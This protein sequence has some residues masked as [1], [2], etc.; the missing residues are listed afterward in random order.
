MRKSHPA[1]QPVT[2]QKSTSIRPKDISPTCA[3]ADFTLV[4]KRSISGKVLGFKRHA[5]CHRAHCKRC[6][7]PEAKTRRMLENRGQYG[8]RGRKEAEI[9]A[10]QKLTSTGCTVHL[11]YREP[12]SK[13]V[14]SCLKALHR[15]HLQQDG[16]AFYTQ[17]GGIDFC[18]TPQSAQFIR[19]RLGKPTEQ[20]ELKFDTVEQILDRGYKAF[21]GWGGHSR[22]KI[23]GVKPPTDQSLF[24]ELYPVSI[25][26]YNCRALD[27]DD[28]LRKRGFILPEDEPEAKAKAKA[29]LELRDIVTAAKASGWA[30][31]EALAVRNCLRAQRRDGGSIIDEKAGGVVPLSREDEMQAEHTELLRQIAANTAVLPSMAKDVSAAARALRQI[32]AEYDAGRITKDER[33][34]RISRW[35]N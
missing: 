20:G 27:T 10:T 17:D 18:A 2:N 24:P 7:T 1:N 15:S 33:D 19:E 35:V 25:T 13:E 4:T 29:E 26:E 11:R 3:D 12:D 8:P 28:R 22:A 34:R 16:A 9:R 23:F 5:P 21:R 32:L 31:A 6:Q 30:P 14:R